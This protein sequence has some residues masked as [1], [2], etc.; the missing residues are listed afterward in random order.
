MT[1]WNS[2][3]FF[4]P[5]VQRGHSREMSQRAWGQPAQWRSAQVGTP[6]CIWSARVTLSIGCGED[7]TLAVIRESAVHLGEVKTTKS[8]R[9]REGKFFFVIKAGKTVD[10]CRESERYTGIPRLAPHH[11]DWQASSAQ[12]TTAVNTR[13][14]PTQCE[15]KWGSSCALCW[16]Y[17]P[18]SVWAWHYQLK[19]MLRWV[20]DNSKYS[21]HC[22]NK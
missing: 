7:E 14:R 2:S 4:P 3:T 15:G 8:D 10:Y 20:N 11:H 19:R 21:T 5:E 9:P 18:W 6:L 1:S 13:T 16:C 17:W 12:Q 22:L